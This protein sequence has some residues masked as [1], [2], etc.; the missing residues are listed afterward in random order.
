MLKRV[1]S[2]Y[3]ERGSWI[4]RKK[5]KSLSRPDRL[6]FLDACSNKKKIRRKYLLTLLRGFAGSIL[7]VVHSYHYFFFIF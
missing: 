1:L 2:S 6:L 3:E 7:S 4:A 5:S